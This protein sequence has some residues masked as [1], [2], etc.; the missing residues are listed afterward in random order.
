MELEL[1]NKKGDNYPLLLDYLFRDESGV[2]YSK[3]AKDSGF[4]RQYIQSIKN[5]GILDLK[6]ERLAVLVKASNKD[7]TITIV[8]GKPVIEKRNRI[9]RKAKKVS[10]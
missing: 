10:K 5:K 7:I 3:I 8:N 2:D 6:L 9:E 1:K 4:S